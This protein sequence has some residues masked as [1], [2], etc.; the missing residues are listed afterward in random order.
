MLMLHLCHIALHKT[1]S[2]QGTNATETFLLS[3]RF[4]ST[5]SFDSAL[6]GQRYFPCRLF[7][8]NIHRSANGKCTT[9]TFV[10]MHVSR[11]LHKDTSIDKELHIHRSPVRL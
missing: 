8:G 9:A 11:A 5:Q 3:I 7:T 1:L 2:S 10:E 6:R 4:P